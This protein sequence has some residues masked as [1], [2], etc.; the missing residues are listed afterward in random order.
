MKQLWQIDYDRARRYDPEIERIVK[1]Y[2]G[3]EFFRIVPTDVNGVADQKYG[4]D[5][6]I[7]ETS[8]GGLASRIRGI[9][10]GDRHLRYYDI[11]IRG[12]TE[13]RKILRGDC[14]ALYFYAWAHPYKP[15]QL[16]AWMVI[17]TELIRT[18]R[19]LQE[20]RRR[21]DPEEPGRSFL[22]IRI[23]RLKEIQAIVTAS[24]PWFDERKGEWVL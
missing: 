9:G 20:A 22:T 8:G 6:E 1:S 15:K 5:Y 16:T 23:E 12:E 10:G 17:K 13:E 19:L 14:P 11:A 18:H 7:I 24:W 2:L 21:Q 4:R 3:F